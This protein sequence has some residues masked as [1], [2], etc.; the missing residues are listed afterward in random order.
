MRRAAHVRNTGRPVRIHGAVTDKTPSPV[1]APSSLS[2]TPSGTSGRSVAHQARRVRTRARHKPPRAAR[3]RFILPVLAGCLFVAGMGTMSY[4]AAAHWISE[5]VQSEQLTTYQQA[6]RE[7]PP[8]ERNRVLE[9]AMLY[10]STLISGEVVDPFSAT[11]SGARNDAHDQRYFSQL[12]GSDT[13]GVMARLSIPRIDLNLPVYHGTS[14]RVLSNGVGHLQ[15]TALPVG[16][17]GTHAV[18]TGHR[19]LAE[20]EL[21]TR[22][23][24]VK[25]GDLVTV[26]VYGERLSY[27]VVESVVVL[28][29]Q[30]DLLRPVA[31]KD[32][33]T[34]VTC[35]PIGINTHRILVTAERVDTPPAAAVV[36]TLAVPA[37]PF[38]GEVALGAV[39]LGMGV[40]TAATSRIVARRAAAP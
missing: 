4:P 33:L 15:G 1:T 27:R 10:N 37:N 40:L 38:P 39:L 35:T 11:G 9:A 31:G 20:S 28:P 14:D 6:V 22:L 26:T 17:K 19:G 30:T 3:G 23:D 21:F 13:N 5:L 25:V 32:L 36:A 34:L 16:G 7:M 18:L 24:E 2:G 29:D 12:G 8:A